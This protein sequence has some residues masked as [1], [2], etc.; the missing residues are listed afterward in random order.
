MCVSF[1]SVSLRRPVDSSPSS[2]DRLAWGSETGT[3]ECWLAVEEAPRSAVELPAS[4]T[5]QG[6]RERQRAIAEEGRGG[7]MFGKVR[8]EQHCPVVR[9]GIFGQLSRVRVLH[10]QPPLSSGRGSLGQSRGWRASRSCPAPPQL[11]ERG[12][13]RGMEEEAGAGRSPRLQCRAFVTSLNKTDSVLLP[14]A[15][16]CATWIPGQR[17][18][19]RGCWEHTFIFRGK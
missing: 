12:N 17:G 4:L 10:C 15:H 3:S 5:V 8:T 13:K 19:S 7:V 16:V 9:G 18:T 6:G 11:T 14:C 2:V 1:I